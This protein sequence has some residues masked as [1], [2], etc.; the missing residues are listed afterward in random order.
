MGSSRS[1]RPRSR[2]SDLDGLPERTRRDI[3]EATRSANVCLASAFTSC[4]LII[5]MAHVV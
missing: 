3:E 1:R 2:G 4:F 5:V